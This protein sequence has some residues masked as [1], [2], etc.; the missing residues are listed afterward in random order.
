[1]KN[2]MHGAALTVLILSACNTSPN[3]GDGAVEISFCSTQIYI[4]KAVEITG[5]AVYQRREFTPSGLGGVDSQDYPIRHAEIIVTSN[6]SGGRVQCGV[7]N[8]LGYFSFFIPKGTTSYELSI[9]SRALNDSLKVSVLNSPSEKKPYS[10]KATFDGLANKNFGTLTAPATGSLEGGAFNIYDQILNANNFL[11][12][13]TDDCQS[14][15][16]DCA[17]FTV[18]PKA[19]V[20]WAPGV[21]PASYF[22]IGSAISFFEQDSAVLYILGGLNGNV[23]DED[24]DHFDNSV[25][26][27]EY[28]HFL[29]SQFSASDSPGGSHDANSVI[30]PRLAWSEGWA[31]FFGLAVSGDP[32]YR[33]TY[34][35]SDGT[36]GYYF[37]ND[38]ETNSPS[39]DVPATLGEGNFREFS[40]TRALWDSID[41]H[42]VSGAGTN[43]AVV[44]AATAPFSELWTVLS[45]SNGIKNSAN[46]FRNYGLFMQL[47]GALTGATDLSSIFTAELQKPNQDDFAAQYVTGGTC[48]YTLSTTGSGETGSFETSHQFR[49]NDFFHYTHSGG[50]LSVQ[51]NRTGGA[52]DIDLYLYDSDYIFGESGDILASSHDPTP[53]DGGTEEINQTVPAGHYMINVMLFTAG[54]A[55]SANYKLLINGSELC[56]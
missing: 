1:M 55:K 16:T 50:T 14:A 43:E 56:P 25:I 45:G 46:Y 19:T 40:I 36:S 11:R 20:Y 54:T 27:H 38:L 7:T 22:G 49:S 5:R 53:A 18:A 52:G 44:D 12:A 15:F 35:N 37:L 24:T 13:Q 34:G 48:T 17:P 32:T 28:G 8:T 47:R 30:D 21:N 41:P 6:T 9:N 2:T 3:G 33:D 10:I 39:Q 31:N 26:I 42:P 4:E 29:E 51:L 23:D